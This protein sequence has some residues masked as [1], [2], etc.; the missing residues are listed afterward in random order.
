M[1]S[2]VTFSQKSGRSLRFLRNLVSN[3]TLF[4][5][6][7]KIPKNWTDFNIAVSTPPDNTAVPIE[8]KSPLQDLISTAKY[9]KHKHST[10][11]NIKIQGKAGLIKLLLSI[12]I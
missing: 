1:N 9:P 2:F 5:S 4:N 11:T 12:F 3:I 8:T 7:L 10:P 6:S